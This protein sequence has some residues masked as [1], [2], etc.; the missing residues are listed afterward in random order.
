M[1]SHGQVSG[2]KLTL[3]TGGL[4]FRKK[5]SGFNMCV[6]DELRGKDYAS[7]TAVRSAFTSAAKKCGKVA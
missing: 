5:A 6:G 2:I 7:R 1:V 3:G 4:R